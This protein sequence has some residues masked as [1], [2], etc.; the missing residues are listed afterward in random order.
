MIVDAQKHFLTCYIHGGLFTMKKLLAAGLAS[1][2]CFSYADNIRLSDLDWDRMV[3][4]NGIIHVPVKELNKGPIWYQ[5]YYQKVLNPT[6]LNRNTKVIWVN[7]NP[8]IR[9][10]SN[11]AYYDFLNNYNVADAKIN[12]FPDDAKLCEPTEELIQELERLYTVHKLESSISG[13]P[14]VCKLKIIYPRDHFANSGIEQAE[15]QL[16]SFLSTNQVVNFSANI[17]SKI[18]PVIISQPEIISTLTKDN[19]L[20][21]NE[22]KQVYTG[23]LTS[24]LYSSLK[25]AINNPTLFGS[26]SDQETM[27]HWQ[28]FSNNFNLQVI[29][30]EQPS[31]EEETDSN[32]TE[33]TVNDPLVSSPNKLADFNVEIHQEE[34]FKPIE[35]QAGQTISRFNIN[36]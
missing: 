31:T 1:L 12:L 16:I 30:D 25:L 6:R 32:E 13:Y 28:V 7:L 15:Q 20:A 35:L 33:E 24:F 3:Q 9:K 23:K 19:I 36:F 29:N 4:D 22:E 14:S 5:D 21:F 17:V 11:N 27:E 26:V 2:A 10:D 8:S 34:A 18:D